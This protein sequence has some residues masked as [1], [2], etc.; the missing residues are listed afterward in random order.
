MFKLV[1]M[2]WKKWGLKK[3][4]CYAT[5]ITMVLFVF[6]TVTAGSA[7]SDTIS[8]GIQDRSIINAAVELYCNLAFIVF[9]GFMLATFI[10]GEYETG[11]MSIMFSY[12]I[13]RKNIFLAKIGSIV[14]FGM[15]SLI[16]S[17]MLIYVALSIIQPLIRIKAEDIPLRNPIFWID[18]IV[19]SVIMVGISF[20]ALPI[21]LKMKSSKVTLI[22]SVLIACF[23][24]GNI[25]GYTLTGKWY[26]YI[27]VM[28][29]VLVLIFLSIR[30]A[31]N[32]DV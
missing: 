22:V 4:I 3:Y 24:H 28:L 19:T 16:L 15:T 21:G 5:T 2:E 11:T 14:V 18:M 17:K 30:R 25:N 29:L 13:K 12:P 7:G 32:E 10:V 26:Y 9:I 23:S 20:L 31:E 1:S 27:F 8:M 6:L